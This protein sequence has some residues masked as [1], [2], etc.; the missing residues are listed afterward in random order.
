MKLSMRSDYGARAIVDLALHYG[1]GPV[2]SA[3]IAARQQVPEAYLEQLLTA[4]RK[5]GLIRSTRGPRG[6]HELARHP[7]DITFAEIITTLEGPLVLVDCLEDDTC[8][9]GPTCGIKDVWL[10]VASATRRILDATTVEH[11]AD[12]QRSRE[13]RAMYHI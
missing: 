2:Q 10:E 1:E 13:G 11:L 8:Q 4:L 3:G 9:L 7:S 6:G 12:R 5:A